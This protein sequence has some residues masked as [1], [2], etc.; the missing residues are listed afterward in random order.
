[1]ISAGVAAVILVVAVLPAEYGVDPTG[2]GERIGLR[3][4][5]VSSAIDMSTAVDAAAAA[6]V[7]R[8]ETP[9]RTDQLIVT[10]KPGETAEI[11][12]TMDAGATYVFGW[13]AAGGTVD[14]DMHGA[15]ADGGG[16]EASYW[17]G[18]ASAGGHGSFRAPFTGQHG[19]FWQNT[20]WEP[21]TI[22]VK[23]SG[24]YSRIERIG[25]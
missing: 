3:R 11:K 19:W 23:T 8:S 9:F 4:Q 22:T 13:T 18:E 21:V 15:R 5:R 10:L 17:K 14:F 2:I 7:D 20:T 1:M 12:A 25:N 24:F 16:G 6:T